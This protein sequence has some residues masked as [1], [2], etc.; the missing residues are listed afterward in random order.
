MKFSYTKIASTIFA[1]LLLPACGGGSS[2]S[3]DCQGDNCGD[4]PNPPV[5]DKS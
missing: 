3:P 5:P 2:S 4:T 1:A